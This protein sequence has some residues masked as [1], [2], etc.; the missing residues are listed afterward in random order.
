MITFLL[1][2]GYSSNHVGIARAISTVFELSA[3][4][5]APKVIK[6]IG[7]V[8]AGSMP[9]FSKMLWLAGG[10]SLLFADVK[11]L[12]KMDVTVASGLVGGVILSR[13]GLWGFDLRAQSIIQ[14]VSL[15]RP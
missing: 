10:V 12:K 8:R 15:S 4:W 3:T 7:A 5:I 6:R 1:S 14:E 13:V 11:G 9:C 2:C